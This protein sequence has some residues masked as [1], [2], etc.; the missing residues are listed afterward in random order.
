MTVA[1]RPSCGSK[2]THAPAVSNLHR[3]TATQ[4]GTGG[5][6]LG[7]SAIVLQRAELFKGLVH[8]LSI[9]A[10][11][12]EHIDMLE[13]HAFLL[14]VRWL[15]RRTEL[16]TA[17]IVLLCD[18]SFGKVPTPKGRLVSTVRCDVA[19]LWSCWMA[20]LS[21]CYLFPLLRCLP[22]FLCVSSGGVMLRN[23]LTAVCATFTGEKLTVLV[24][25]AINETSWSWSDAC[26]PVFHSLV[27]F[28]C[29]VSRLGTARGLAVPCNGVAVLASSFVFPFPSAV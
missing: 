10:S 24:P 25:S 9:K 19:L 28:F 27:S 15:L 18:S 12:D 3:S 1:C 2:L 21:T 13:G 5:S 20:S 16:Q 22:T 17:R 29:N 23:P 11:R 26:T 8:V 6:I 7:V 4:G 14:L